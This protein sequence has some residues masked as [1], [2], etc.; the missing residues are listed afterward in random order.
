MD[1]YVAMD[2][3]THYLNFEKNKEAALQ[4]KWQDKK[5]AFLQGKTP[6]PELDNLNKPTGVLILYGSSETGKTALV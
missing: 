4:Q 2:D 6:P 3:I 1:V 5:P